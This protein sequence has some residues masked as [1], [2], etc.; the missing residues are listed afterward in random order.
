MQTAERAGLPGVL[1]SEALAE[2]A[3]AADGAMRSIEKQLPRAFPDKIR[4]SVKA[5]LSSRLRKI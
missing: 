1:A 3:E 2:V 5:A 4:F